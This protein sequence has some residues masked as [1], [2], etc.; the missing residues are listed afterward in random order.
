MLVNRNPGPGCGGLIA[1]CGAIDRALSTQA[2]P[3]PTRDMRR[4]TR[5]PRSVEDKQPCIRIPSDPSVPR[6]FFPCLSRTACMWTLAHFEHRTADSSP[7][8]HA[9]VPG[10]CSQLRSTP[11]PGSA[12]PR[13]DLRP[14]A[15][16]RARLHR[17]LGPAKAHA[18]IPGLQHLQTAQ[19]ALRRRAP[20]VRQL[21]TP[22]RGLRDDRSQKARERIDAQDTGGPR[23]PWAA[24][25]SRED[26]LGT[27]ACG[28]P[29]GAAGARCKSRECRPEPIH[30]WQ[31]SRGY[32]TGGWAADTYT[33]TILEQHL[34]VGPIPQCP[35]QHD[36][37]QRANILG[38]SGIPRNAQYHNA[39]SSRR[40]LYRDS[41][42]RHQHR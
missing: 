16:R 33:W 1:G 28:A 15:P 35:R 9:S 22:Q 2:D 17:G 39:S 19:G 30:G 31:D 5:E 41:G 38:F 34:G 3:D 18:P 24:R 27:R 40:R 7:I 14:L 21:H 37:Q 13:P 23:P 42:H 20:Q 32:G 8:H 12:R 6:V 29:R 10:T 4:Q 25:V 36:K 26:G 11:Q